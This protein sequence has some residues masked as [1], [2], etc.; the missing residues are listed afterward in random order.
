[1][2]L[3]PRATSERTNVYCRCAGDS[4]VV[5]VAGRERD[6]RGLVGCVLCCGTNATSALEHVKRMRSVRARGMLVKAGE[7]T[8]RH[9]EGR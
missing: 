2:A 6:T 8:A 7:A 3:K 9:V 4:S 1:M 5:Q